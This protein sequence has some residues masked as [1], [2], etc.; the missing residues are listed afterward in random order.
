MLADRGD[1]LAEA[2]GQAHAAD[3]E[4]L[5]H[6][7]ADDLDLRRAAADVDDERP[8][9]ERADPAQRHRGLLVAAQQARREAV[10][11]LDL[12]EE[13]LAVLG[14]AHGARRDAE[15]PLGAERLELA[16]VVGED[17]A[18]ARD[19]D[20]EEAAPLVDALAEPGDLE[21][22]DDLVERPVRVGDEQPGR[23]RPEVDRCDPHLRGYDGR[24]APDRVADLVD[25]A[26]EHVQPRARAPQLGEL[27]P[28]AASR[29]RPPASRC[30][31]ISPVAPLDPLE[32]VARPSPLS[33]FGRRGRL[34][35]PL[36]LHRSQRR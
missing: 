8:G 14:V 30:R 28:P 32:L 3:V 36:A 25:R 18:D 12:A 10:A 1:V 29:S 9:L 20:G 16:P 11:P 35:A 5:A 27:R 23:V 34:R 19:R 13:G 26:R 4:A 7:R 24:D 15:R 22:A 31:S 21:P 33:L 6:V 17:V 2:L